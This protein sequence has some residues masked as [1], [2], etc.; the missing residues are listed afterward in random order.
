[1]DATLGVPYPFLSMS[2]KQYLWCLWNYI[3]NDFREII[4][5]FFWYLSNFTCI[6]R[7]IRLSLANEIDVMHWK[8]TNLRLVLHWS[9]WISALLEHPFFG[10]VS[11]AQ[12]VVSMSGVVLGGVVEVVGSNLA[13][14]KIFTASIGSVGSLYPS[15]YIYRVNQHQSLILE[16]NDVCEI[17]FPH[18]WYL[19]NFT[20][21]LGSI[22][23]S[24][25]NE[26]DVM[27]WKG[28]NIRRNFTCILGSIRLSLANEIDAMHWK[29]TNI[30]RILHIHR[31]KPL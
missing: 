26:I 5:P 30:R 2:L 27:H 17:I 12:L 7:S 13:G 19:S 9:S 3:S 6:L 29:G 10:D 8:G 4:F 21:I 23:L 16:S 11:V 28:T 15:V 14:V 24:L 1:M 31:T 25:A 18:F 22:R 20:C